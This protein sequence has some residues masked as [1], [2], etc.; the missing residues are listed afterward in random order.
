MIYFNEFD[1][2]ASVWI[3]NLFPDAT[4]D[5]RSIVHVEATDAFRFTRCHFF[6]GIGGWEYALQLAGWP[7]DRAVWTG[8]CPCPPFSC[9]GKKQRCP[10]CGGR[11]VPCPRRTGYFIC[12]SCEHAWYADER[13]LWPEFWRLIRDCLPPVVFGEQVASNDGRIWF[14]GVR[15]TLERIGYAVGSADLA[16]ASVGAPHIRQRL[17]WVADASGAER[18]RWTEPERKHGRA[19]HAANRS[20]TRGMADAK[21]SDR[22]AESECDEERS[23][24]SVSQDRRPDC[25]M[26]DSADSRWRAGIVNDDAGEQHPSRRGAACGLGVTIEPGLE[27]HAGDGDDG[28]QPGRIDADTAGSTAAAGDIGDWGEYDILSCRDGK[29]RRTKPGIHPLAHG[30]S[31]RVGRL[32]G[33]G[34]AIV[35][36]VAAAFIKAFMET[37]GN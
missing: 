9:A 12:L 18:G 28:N 24:R 21:D 2:F 15:A 14:A 16:A 33:Y 30:V 13:H 31:S 8:S 23:R 26:A 10:A 34:N 3:K 29:A 5:K 27:R 4:I 17:F 25:W 37:S 36:Q 35:P 1:P 11:P 19:I 32:R 7:E 20:D 6:G 22:R